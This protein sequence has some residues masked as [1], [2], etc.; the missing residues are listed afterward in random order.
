MKLGYLNELREQCNHDYL[1]NHPG[2]N[3]FALRQNFLQKMNL[4]MKE[5]EEALLGDIEFFMYDIN[6]PGTH[7][8]NY[9]NGPSTTLTILNEKQRE[10]KSTFQKDA[11]NII[12]TTFFDFVHKADKIGEDYNI[13]VRNS[14]QFLSGLS[15]ENVK[16]QPE[17]FINTLRHRK[18][19]A[20]E[21]NELFASYID[22]AVKIFKETKIPEND[23]EGIANFKKM[24]PLG[25]MF[26]VDNIEEVFK[27]LSNE[28]LDPEISQKWNENKESYKDVSRYYSGLAEKLTNPLYPYFD[29]KSFAKFVTQVTDPANFYGYQTHDIDIPGLPIDSISLESLK[30]Y[31]YNVAV[32]KM[33]NYQKAKQQLDIDAVENDV[34]FTEDGIKINEDEL[35]NDLANDK[36]IFVHKGNNEKYIISNYKTGFVSVRPVVPDHDWKKVYEYNLGILNK[37]TRFYILSSD[38]Y[39]NMRNILGQLS[40]GEGNELQLLKDLDKNIQKYEENFFLKKNK[41]DIAVERLNCVKAIKS[42]IQI[43]LDSKKFNDVENRLLNENVNNNNNNHNIVN[44]EN[45]NSINRTQI[46]LNEVREQNNQNLND[47]TLDEDS[48]ENSNDGPEYSDDSEMS[49]D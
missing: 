46:I 23:A 33:G 5:S 3:V 27:S 18:I 16:L 13:P 28:E 2:A 1:A 47:V 34:V 43:I 24:Y 22:E 21:K 4:Y 45:Q 38:E 25:Q 48:L 41:S 12:G 40:R 26:S 36:E 42:D 19:S 29:D 20:K 44:D 9:A 17:V 32:M 10:A 11:I 49:N 39:K 30:G 14:K 8:V 6:K 35:S 31:E 37:G 7:T 15:S